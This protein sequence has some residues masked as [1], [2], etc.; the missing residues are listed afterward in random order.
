M[1]SKYQKEENRISL[2]LE[3]Y[4]RDKN[5]K[6]SALARDFA[7]PYQRLRVVVQRYE[8]CLFRGKHEAIYTTRRSS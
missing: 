4:Q 1:A 6:L 8:L 7:V 2:A 3:I 5:R